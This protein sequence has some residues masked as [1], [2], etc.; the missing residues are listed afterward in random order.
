MAERQLIE[1]D[2]YRT[3]YVEAGLPGEA[4]VPT[5]LLVHDGWFGADAATLWSAVIALLAGDFRILA[6]DMLGFGGT[7]KAVYFDRSMYAYRAAHLGSFVRAMHGSGSKPGAFGSKPGAFGS[8]S[9]A[10]GSELHAA[11][12][13]LGGSIL[14][15]DAVSAAPQLQAASIVSISGSGGPWRSQF[16]AAELGTFDG[17]EADIERMLGHMADT[18][19]GR[20][21]FIATRF[22]NSALP[23]HAECLLTSAI[24]VPIRRAP[25]PDA[26]PQALAGV[27]VPV[28]FVAGQRDPLLDAG[29]EQNLVGVSPLVEVRPVDTKHAPSLDHADL[30]ADIIRQTAGRA[31]ALGNQ[32]I[33]GEH[34]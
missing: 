31:R 11:G 32:E 22:A 21:E 19:A 20:D 30:I 23:G 4:G 13:S 27:R 8:E 28:T 9:G 17:T 7:D 29:W 34:G 1:H 6:P 14:V 16:G 15:R 25:R 5:L 33:A 18:F 24:K 10:F 3:T 12:T 26:W 2:G